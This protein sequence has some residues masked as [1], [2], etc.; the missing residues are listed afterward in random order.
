M[1][2][3]ARCEYR[4]SRTEENHHGNVQPSLSP[5]NSEIYNSQI[6]RSSG[7]LNPSEIRRRSI[8][9]PRTIQAPW[10]HKSQWCYGHSRISD[11]L[12]LKTRAAAR[13]KQTPSVWGVCSSLLV[14]AARGSPAVG[15]TCSCWL[16]SV[17]I[18]HKPLLLLHPAPLLLLSA[19]L[20][21]TAASCH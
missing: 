21:L 18:S 9:E 11:L 17:P 16:I 19:S 20:R 3:R 14:Q 5:Q 13:G 8:F 12:S 10:Q 6:L 1:S 2:C 15:R 7:Y 4:K